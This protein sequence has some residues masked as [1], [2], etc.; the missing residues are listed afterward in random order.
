MNLQSSNALFA[1]EHQIDDLEPRF[2]RD[3]VFS[4]IVPYG[5]PIRSAITAFHTH[6]NGIVFS[7]KPFRRRSVYCLCARLRRRQSLCLRRQSLLCAYPSGG[8][9][10]SRT[11]SL[12]LFRAGSRAVLAGD[13]SAAS[14]ARRAKKCRL[15]SR[16][17]SS[18]PRVEESKESQTE[19]RAAR[20]R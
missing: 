9:C 19:R 18:L 1:C 16:P 15:D 11:R 20:L 10:F 7:S 4:K 14:V 5:E 8:F 3:L 6:L 2:E 13:I 12:Q 17:G